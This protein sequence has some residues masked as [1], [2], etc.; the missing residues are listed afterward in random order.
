VRPPGH[1]Y[2]FVIQQLTRSRTGMPR[3]GVAIYQI[4]LTGYIQTK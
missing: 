1:G 2:L 4:V 3:P